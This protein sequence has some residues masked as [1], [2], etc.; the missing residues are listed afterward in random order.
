MTDTISPFRISEHAARIARI[1]DLGSDTAVDVAEL[2]RALGGI[3]DVFAGAIEVERAVSG[4]HA[5]IVRGKG[6]FTVTLQPLT[7]S[8]H[9]RFEMAASVGRYLLHWRRLGLETKPAAERRR[10]YP[11]GS[12]EGWT[13]G[14][15]FAMALLMPEDAFRRVHLE[16]GGDAV[17]IAGA[18]D[19]PTSKVS[20]RA[21]ALKLPLAPR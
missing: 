14:Y 13:E 21:S 19:V 3:I 16:H 2:V 10:E 5:L 18:F 20:A 1:Y 4:G 7:S 11:Y 8:V 12:G 6:D 9:D 17:A 15:H